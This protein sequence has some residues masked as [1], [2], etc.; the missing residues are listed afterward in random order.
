VPDIFEKS[1]LAGAAG[2]EFL[3]RQDRIIYL[4]TEPTLQGAER[5]R[6]SGGL[7]TTDDK[8]VDIAGGVLLVTGKGAS[9]SSSRSSKISIRPRASW[10]I[11]GSMSPICFSSSLSMS[12][13]E[14]IYSAARRSGNVISNVIGSRGDSSKPSAR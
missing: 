2:V 14:I 6:K 11:S 4:A 8:D 3:A 9:R 5:F 12:K 7:R 1:I 13:N 10:R